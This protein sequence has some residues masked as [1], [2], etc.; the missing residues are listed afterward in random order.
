MWSEPYVYSTTGF[1][2]TTVS[3]P[4]FDHSDPENPVLIGVAALDLLISSMEALIGGDANA[5][6]VTVLQ[7]L[8]ARA[9]SNCP[10]STV[11]NATAECELQALR[12]ASGGDNA[13]CADKCSENLVETTA[14]RACLPPSAYPQEDIAR[15]PGD[16]EHERGF[17]VQH[18]VWHN[19]PT[20]LPVHASGSVPSGWENEYHPNYGLDRWTYNFED[21]ACCAIGLEVPTTYGD[22]DDPT[23][24]M[25]RV[26][27]EDEA[28]TTQAD[29]AGDS[30]M[31]V[32]TPL[33]WTEAR[34][35]CQS[36]GG[37][38]VNIRSA[39]EEA[40]IKD[41]M[42]GSGITQAWLC[43]E[44]IQ[45]PTR[46]QYENWG[47]DVQLSTTSS[48]Y[49]PVDK[50][51]CGIGE[52]WCC[53]GTCN[54]CQPAARQSCDC[55]DDEDD[56]SEAPGSWDSCSGHFHRNRLED[57]DC[58]CQD[59]PDGMR[60]R[61]DEQEK[62]L[63]TDTTIGVLG[64]DQC[65]I[66]TQV[67]DGAMCGYIRTQRIYPSGELVD[68]WGEE[69]CP[70]RLPYIC[71]TNVD[72]DWVRHC[73]VGWDRRRPPTAGAPR[74]TLGLVLAAAVSA[75]SLVA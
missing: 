33:S 11:S 45:A 15:P 20:T 65:V 56:G 13:M 62:E 44:V 14:I 54:D 40:T 48:Y 7:M 60:V 6:R 43:N 28:Q 69:Q 23:H 17:A 19:N 55:K 58:F 63:V 22:H 12:R 1:L 51:D 18:D 26:V 74:A 59:C 10:V 24:G 38:L 8:N 32:E 71:N 49:E 39:A 46:G 70:Q 50:I 53:G 42:A 4:V 47:S 35:A 72:Q 75:V 31:M 21:V 9:A 25:C 36:S 57:P 3:S 41:L 67:Y 2:G 52:A 27:G 16:A 29:A 68:D 34:D 30:Y 73:H 5:A 64:R 61:V 37:Q 66:T